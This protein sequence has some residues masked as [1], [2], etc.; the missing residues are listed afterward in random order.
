MRNLVIAGVVLALAACANQQVGGDVKQV[1]VTEENRQE[2]QRRV[3]EGRELT[4]DE[5][6]LL[7]AYLA[8]QAGGQLPAGRT[9]GE[10]IAEQRGFEAASAAAPQQVADAASR[11]VTGLLA[12]V[13]GGLDAGIAPDRPNG[14]LARCQKSLASEAGRCLKTRLAEFVQRGMVA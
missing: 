6:R 11:A 3:R 13:F 10:L 12:D 8:R 14:A 9:I 7:D 5:I 4:G 1:A 2:L